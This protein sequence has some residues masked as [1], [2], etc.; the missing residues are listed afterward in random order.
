RDIRERMR[1]EDALAE[2]E[3]RLADLYDHSPDVFAYVDLKSSRILEF[4]ATLQRTLGYSAEELS[5]IPFS[6][7][8][9]P[10]S[11]EALRAFEEALCRTAE[12]RDVE[13]TLVR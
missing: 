10:E 11:R 7:L 8:F 4:N 2:R 13:M 3:R 1:R 12:E 5:A 6:S 9:S